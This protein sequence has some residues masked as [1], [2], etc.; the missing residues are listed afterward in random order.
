MGNDHDADAVTQYFPP[1]SRAETGGE[2]DAG[3]V[4]EAGSAPGSGA[5]RKRRFAPW[6]QALVALLAA[7]VA[8]GGATGNVAVAGAGALAAMVAAFALPGR[9][10]G[11]VGATVVAGRAP[12]RLEPR[13][14]ALVVGASWAVAAL[15]SLLALF[16]VPAGFTLTAGVLVALFSAA[17]VWGAMEAVSRR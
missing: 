13:S 6:E 15:A 10:P 9:A 4:A 3:A 11:E 1:V 17:V 5:G 2:P 14:V 16:F 12:G 8:F 7:V